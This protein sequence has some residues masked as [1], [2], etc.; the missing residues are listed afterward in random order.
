MD[1]TDD[2]RRISSRLPINS[3]IHY[4]IKGIM[5]DAEGELDNLS[6]TGA[7]IWA[8]QKLS[9]GTE[10]QMVI[11][12]SDPAEPAIVITANIVRIHPLHKDYQFG[13]GCAIARAEDPQNAD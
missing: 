11:E 8:D 4:H 3:K 1:T 13:Y 5:A 6:E 9:I 12:S 7:M 10:L 2:D